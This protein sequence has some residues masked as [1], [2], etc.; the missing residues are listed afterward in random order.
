MLIQLTYS[1]QLVE[2]GKTTASHL[3]LEVDP[4]GIGIYRDTAHM[5]LSI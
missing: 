5:G 1:N 2:I 3:G 4:D